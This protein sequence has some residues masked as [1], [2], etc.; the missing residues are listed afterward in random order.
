MTGRALAKLL[1]G[2]ALGFVGAFVTLQAIDR[3]GPA[4]APDP[5]E[6]VLGPADFDAYCERGPDDRLRAVATTGD[7]FGWQCVGTVGGFWTAEPV[8]ADE[9]CRSEHGA[10]AVGRLVGDGDVDGWFCVTSP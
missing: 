1:L 6:V 2:L 5:L 9:V 10:Q 7:A 8:T 3:F 4:D